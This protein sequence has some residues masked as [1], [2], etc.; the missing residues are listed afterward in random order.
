MIL[1]YLYLGF[2]FLVSLISFAQKGSLSG[3]ILDE[4]TKETLPGANVVIEGT[5]IGT[6]TDLDGNYTLRN[7]DPGT[8]NVVVSFI[9]YQTKKIEKVVIKPGQTTYINASLGTS[10]QDLKEVVVVGSVE[11]ETINAMMVLQKNTISVSDGISAE[12]IRKTPDRSSSDVLKRI[13]GA[14]I[15]EGK[16]AVIRGLNDRYNAAFINGAPLPSTESDRKAFAF[17]IFPSALLDNM[18]ILKTATPDMPADFGGGIIEI[19]TRSIPSENTQDISFS[20]GYNT[21]THGRESF[22]YEGGKRDWL[23]LDDGKRALPA[24]LPSSQTYNLVETT[25][26]KR[27]EYGKLLENNWALK[28]HNAT[29]P[30]MNFQYSLAR[31]GTLLGKEVGAFAALTYQNNLNYTEILRQEFNDGIDGAREKEYTYINDRYSENVMTGALVNL[32]IKLNPNHKIS[33]KSLYNINSTDI[34]N[35][36]NGARFNA[37]TLDTNQIEYRSIR[38]FTSN[39]FGSAQLSGEHLLGKTGIRVDWVGGVSSIERNVPNLRS[40]LYTQDLNSRVWTASIPISGS[41]P[42]S[43]GYFFYSRNNEDIRSFQ[44][45]ITVPLKFIPVVQTSIKLG[46]YMSERLRNFDARQF[47]ITRL[48]NPIGT[49]NTD[50]LNLSEDKIFAPENFGAIRP[51][52]PKRNGFKLEDITKAID[53]YQASSLLT[54]GYFMFDNK[55]FSKLRLVWGGRIENFNQTLNTFDVDGA[56]IEVNTLKSDFLPSANI[57]FS[58]TEKT[59][60]RFSYSRTLNRPEF[61]ELAPFGFFDLVTF[62]TVYGN[63]DLKRAKIENFDLR[64]ETFFGRGQMLSVSGF[65]KQFTDPIETFVRV[66]SKEINF[67]NAPKANNYGIELEYRMLLST[68]LFTENKILDRTTLFFNGAIIVS[69]VDAGTIVGA[70]ELKRPLQGQSP[71]IFNG[72][73]NYNDDEN[74]WSASFSSNIVGRRIFIIGNRNQPSIWENQRWVLDL[75]VAKRFLKNFEAKIN[76][77]DLLAQDLIFYQ[78]TDKNG[79]YEEGK[80]DLIIK[81]RFGQTLSF[82]L[83]YRF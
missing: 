60:F 41:S 54:A 21:I 4:E 56:T 63:K 73:L 57:I 51:T 17:D 9:S 26:Q 16:F 72:G 77:R 24:G 6:M 35:I 42:T 62:L 83:S 53:S 50:L 71:Y 18:R 38:W 14:S 12:L 52:G 31:V 29:R 59:N 13:S 33:F 5:V 10:A 11:K 39:Q 40:M 30:N 44:T 3:K 37:G 65:Y 36:Q 49:F 22:T 58:A 28:T 66:D 8:Y 43:G 45:N 81:N 34:V 1:R 78:D 67:A 76:V 23:G 25:N 46:G 82:S 68:L 2:L 80:D 61:R 27:G 20:L 70:D 75:Q 69:E 47:G 32:S 55:L 79:K 74:G 64:Y 15:Q 7:I 19:N 48:N